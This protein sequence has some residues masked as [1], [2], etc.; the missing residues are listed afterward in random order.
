MEEIPSATLINQDVEVE[1]KEN[2]TVV[3]LYTDY[4]NKQKEKTYLWRS[5]NKETWKEYDRKRKSNLYQNDPVYRENILNKQRI[6]R[7]KRI[8][9][10]KITEKPAVA[11]S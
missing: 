6:Q 10:M 11:H 7:Q 5:N 4:K 9:K 8:E 2:I 1:P 3:F